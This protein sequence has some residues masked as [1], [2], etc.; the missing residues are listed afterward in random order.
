[1]RDF[2]R[3]KLVD[4]FL[5]GAVD[6]KVV[7]IPKASNAGFFYHLVRGAK[8]SLKNVDINRDD[9]QRQFNI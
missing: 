6:Q 5:G 2:T 3:C 7:H 1:M 9:N 4:S 8:A